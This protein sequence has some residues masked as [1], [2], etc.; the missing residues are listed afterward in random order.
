MVTDVFWDIPYIN[1][2]T[3]VVLRNVK[4]NEPFHSGIVRGKRKIDNTFY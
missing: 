4:G 3:K 1:N 2:W